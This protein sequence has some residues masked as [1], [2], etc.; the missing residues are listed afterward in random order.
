MN[1][2]LSK[3]GMKIF[4]WRWMKN[5]LMRAEILESSANKANSN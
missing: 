4:I 3:Y 2:Q 1:G 5:E